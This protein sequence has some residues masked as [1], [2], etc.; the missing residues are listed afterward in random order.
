M[1]EEKN[2]CLQDLKTFKSVTQN[3][4]GS[5]EIQVLRGPLDQALAPLFPI[6][7]ETMILKMQISSRADPRQ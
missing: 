4:T 2:F 1:N 6:G 3:P 5:S 7:M